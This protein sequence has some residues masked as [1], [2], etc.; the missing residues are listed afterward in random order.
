M[1]SILSAFS[2]AEL[3]LVTDLAKSFSRDLKS[4]TLPAKLAAAIVLVPAIA[5]T[6][7]LM[8]TAKAAAANK[9]APPVGS[10]VK[11][12]IVTSARAAKVNRAMPKAFQAREDLPGIFGDNDDIYLYFLW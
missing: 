11:T 8:P 2:N 9:L 1:V 4:P 5:A 3:N 6:L 12:P 7:L 10:V